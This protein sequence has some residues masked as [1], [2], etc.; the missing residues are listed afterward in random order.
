MRIVCPS[1][2]AEYEVPDD[3][4]AKRPRKV[5]CAKC[6]REW[7]PFS[8]PPAAPTSEPINVAPPIR[9]ELAPPPVMD[10]GY[11][12]QESYSPPAGAAAG[13]TLAGQAE[14]RPGA[15]ARRAAKGP[16]GPPGVG[17]VIAWLVTAAILA[18]GVGVV[19]LKRPEIVALWPPAQRLFKL[20]GLD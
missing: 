10:P 17:V 6:A 1:C 13:D 7:E 14:P 12:P 5:R 11:A 19:W 4:L 2:E 9:T 3:L 20:L 8:A 18:A 15:K 16:G